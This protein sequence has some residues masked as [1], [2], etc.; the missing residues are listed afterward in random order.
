M[1]HITWHHEAL[2]GQ[3]KIIVMIIVFSIQ[4]QFACFLLWVESKN[5][6]FGGGGRRSENQTVSDLVYIKDLI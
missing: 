4:L 2:H 5:G 6:Y 1:I 3:S